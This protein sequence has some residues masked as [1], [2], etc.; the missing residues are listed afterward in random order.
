MI[1]TDYFKSAHDL[2]WDYAKQCGVNHGVI[3]L[4]EDGN[5]DITF[6]D[7]W[8]AVYKKFIDFGIKPVVVE[9]LPNELHDHIKLCDERRDE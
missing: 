2:T 6:I 8:H 5:F 9:P 1:L 7:H 4:P 3:R